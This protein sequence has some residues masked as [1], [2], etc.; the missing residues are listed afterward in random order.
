[1]LLDVSDRLVV[2][3]GGGAVAARKAA[4]L[5]AAGAMRIRC[6]APAFSD[7]LSDGVERIVEKYDPRHLA[8]AGL[9][10]AATDR[11]E[12]NDAVVNDARRLGLLVNRA[13]GDDALPGD[14][15]TPALLMAGRI[16]IAVASA[17]P[18]LTAAVRNDLAR[19]LDPR[20]V[21]MADAL[22]NLRPMIRA[23]GVSQWRRAEIFREL[24]AD[25]ALDILRDGGL[26]GLKRWLLGRYP[27]LQH[28]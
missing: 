10:F 20:F 23:S 19:R 7:A 26:D 5:L 16:T 14:F 11:P 22:A 9:V 12:V 1:M 15:S 18:A 25:A 13:D 8:G 27:E 4:G 2:I 6:V 21:A 17:S 24:A 3:I 28:G